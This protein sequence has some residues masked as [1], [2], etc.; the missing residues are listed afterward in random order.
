M[1]F[2]IE[3]GLFKLDFT[4]YHAILGIPIDADEKEVRKRYLRIARNLHPDSIKVESEAQ[5]KQANQLLSKLVNPA[6]EE[7]SRNYR[8]YTVRLGHMGKR[9]AA[10][11]G[12]ISL[13]TDVAK[14]LAQSGA[15]IDPAYKSAVQQI[16]AQ[17]YDSPDQ[18]LDKIGQLSELNLVYLMLKEGRG[19][20]IRTPV[21]KV[22]VG[23]ATPG[24]NPSTGTPSTGASGGGVPTGS[25]NSPLPDSTTSRVVE[26]VRRAEGY[27]AKG[28]FAG[29][30]LELRE[31]LK[32][33][34]NNS[35]CHSLLG[36]AYLKQ[37]QATMARVHIKKALEL[38]P[39]EEMALKGKQ[40]LDK[41]AGQKNPAS[42][43][44]KTAASAK[45][46]QGQPSKPSDKSGGGGFLGGLF[47]GKKK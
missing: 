35:R 45:P 40:Y 15:G 25:T 31:A 23:T 8:E 27:L 13:S 4:D 22:P 19:E 9:V 16:A 14:Q 3:Q 17:Q 28:N 5:K 7:L 46:A 33:E 32:L 39:Q 41:L 24:S 29:A 42:G 37:N 47:G 34:Q 26:Y 36:V 1:S 43:G 11:R 30:V 38:N 44:G 10:E 2:Q 21:G 20:G 18:A 12:K 6:Y